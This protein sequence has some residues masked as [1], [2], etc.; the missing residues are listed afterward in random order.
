MGI[1]TASQGTYAGHSADKKYSIGTQ[2]NG[3]YYDI[4]GVTM[5]EG[6]A[7]S[8]TVY[9]MVQGSR[10]LVLHSKK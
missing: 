3:N 9:E 2:Y 10:T 7:K 8:T 6:K 1:V 5:S 4:G